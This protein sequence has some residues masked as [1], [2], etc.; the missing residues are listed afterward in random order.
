VDEGSCALPAWRVTPLRMINSLC[1]I[2]HGP[3]VPAPLSIGRE[4]A[5]NNFSP[6]IRTP[7][8]PCDHQGLF[9]SIVPGVD[10]ADSGAGGETGPRADDV[11]D[12]ALATSGVVFRRETVQGLSRV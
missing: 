5:S 3:G 2:Y 12:V 6:G 1:R 11:A 9:V 8:T 4:A 10:V 7:T